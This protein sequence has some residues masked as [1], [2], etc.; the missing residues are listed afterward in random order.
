MNLNYMHLPLWLEKSWLFKKLYLWRKLYW[1]K[2]S[3]RHYSQFAEDITINRFFPQ[4][5]Q[6][7]FVDV[8]CFHPQKF[9]NTW[10][11]YQNGW[12]G[13][14]IDIDAIKIEAFQIARPADINIS[15][16]VSNQ[17]GEIDYYSNGFYSLTISLDA[18]FA[19]RD[20]NYV[21]RT[22]RCAKLTTLLDESPYRDRQIDLLSVDAE[23]HD[24]EVLASLDFARYAPRLIAVETH[25]PL[26]SQVSESRLYCFLREHEYCLVGWCGLTLIMASKELQ[27]SLSPAAKTTRCAA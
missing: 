24:L 25:N 9:N 22:T 20:P 23:G 18:K 16:A 4:D 13:V 17:E 19:K 26:F 12:R 7:F 15:C 27:R 5:Y 8:G 6:G 10:Q 3:Y 11:L 21:R 14:N 2:S 1:C